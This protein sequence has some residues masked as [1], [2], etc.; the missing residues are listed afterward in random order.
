M[1]ITKL[2]K[3][4]VATVEAIFVVTSLWLISIPKVLYGQRWTG[5]WQSEPLRTQ[6]YLENS[7]SARVKY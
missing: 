3:I 4:R 7:K 1:Q 6:P 5:C 2:F